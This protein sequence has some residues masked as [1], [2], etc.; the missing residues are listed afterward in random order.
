M[1]F[2]TIGII[3]AFGAGAQ[4]IIIGLPVYSGNLVLLSN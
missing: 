1:E 2:G 3:G 4:L